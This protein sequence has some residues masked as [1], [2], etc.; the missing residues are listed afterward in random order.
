MRKNQGERSLWKMLD[1]ELIHSKK[2]NFFGNQGHCKKSYK[3]TGLVALTGLVAQS[4]M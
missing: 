3:N 2:E 4:V 1:S